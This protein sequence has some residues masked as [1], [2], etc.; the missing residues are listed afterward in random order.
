MLTGDECTT[1]DWTIPF[2]VGGAGRPVDVQ[3]EPPSGFC[4]VP[5]VVEVVVTATD[6]LGNSA[7]CMFSVTV[8]QEGKL[9][10]GPDL[11]V[12]IDLTSDLCRLVNSF[13]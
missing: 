3:S 2:A 12:V 10:H 9:A 5:G 6:D 8:N 11:H 13:F 7:N 1:V 4:F